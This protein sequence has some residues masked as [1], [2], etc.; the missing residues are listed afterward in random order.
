MSIRKFFFVSLALGIVSVSLHLTAMSE[1]SRGVQITARAATVLEPD[2]GVV[3]ADARR[4]FSRGAI[5]GDIGLAFALASVGFV[6]TSARKREPARRSMILG[7]LLCYV[8][9]RFVAI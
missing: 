1:I 6:A 3:R 5:L 7:L 4:H 8:L 2:R 9:L